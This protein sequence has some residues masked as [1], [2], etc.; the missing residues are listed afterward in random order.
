MARWRCWLQLSTRLCAVARL[1]KC[2]AYA[3]PVRSS[4][5]EISHAAEPPCRRGKE[6]AMKDSRRTALKTR[7]LF[8]QERIEHTNQPQLAGV[9]VQRAVKGPCLKMESRCRDR[10]DSCVDGN[11]AT[12][13]VFSLFTGWGASN[14]EWCY[15]ASALLWCTALHRKS[16]IKIINNFY[17]HSHI[18]RRENYLPTIIQG[19]NKI[20]Q[21]LKKSTYYSTAPA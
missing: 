9:P 7:H 4:G 14:C 17:F 11:R 18:N 16:T 13:S 2:A 12:K 1:A 21:Q 15:R 8:D 5:V 3:K 6:S 19:S 10:R 20:L